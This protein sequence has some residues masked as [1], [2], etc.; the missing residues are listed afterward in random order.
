[1]L[2]GELLVR[3]YSVPAAARGTAADSARTAQHK[4]TAARAKEYKP[5][6]PTGQGVGEGRFRGVAR[7]TTP[8]RPAGTAGLAFEPD[9]APANGHVN[10]KLARGPTAHV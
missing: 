4:K 5:A 9:Y 8:A 6:I 7:V 2:P 1:M 10:P 3:P